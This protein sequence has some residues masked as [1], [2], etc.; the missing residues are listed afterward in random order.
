MHWRLWH[1]AVVIA[2]FVWVNLRLYGDTVWLGLDGCGLV[3]SGWC[4]GFVWILVRRGVTDW[5]RLPSRGHWWKKQTAVLKRY[6]TNSSRGDRYVLLCP[7]CTHACH[8]SFRER[9]GILQHRKL[10]CRRTRDNSADYRCQQNQGQI[11]ITFNNVAK[12]LIQSHLQDRDVLS[13]GLKRLFCMR[14][15]WAGGGGWTERLV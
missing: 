13:E 5:V 12:P 4:G 15:P 2:H 6:K 14:F 3:G 7:S 11:T 10:T 8:S 1:H 9:E